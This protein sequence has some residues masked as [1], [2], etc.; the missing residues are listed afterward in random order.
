ME[1]SSMLGNISVSDDGLGEEH[2][3]SFESLFNKKF[4]GKAVKQGVLFGQGGW[5][6]SIPNDMWWPFF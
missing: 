4:P 3:I 1:C 2:N 6:T 5:P